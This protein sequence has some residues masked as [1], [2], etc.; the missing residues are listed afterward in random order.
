MA[1]IVFL[2]IPAAGHV[3]PTLGVLA[4]LVK[5]GHRVIAYN[6][7]EYRAKHERAGA[8]FRAYPPMQ[9]YDAVME[10]MDRGD[11]AFNAVMLM[12]A[13]ERVL[14]G[15]MDELRRDQ[16]D[17]IMYDS[18]ASWGRWAAELLG[19]AGVASITT[20]VLTPAS[21]PRIPLV[22]SLKMARNVLRQMPRYLRV[23]SRLKRRNLTELGLFTALMNTGR[24]NLVYTSRALQPNADALDEN[25]VFVG[26]SIAE[27]NDSL[28]VPLDGR[29]LIYVSLGTLHVGS[30]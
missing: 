5:R 16:P 12:K 28:D 1:T 9:E 8:E 13:G 3:N 29:P 25:Y 26:A 14:S 4:E 7:E 17:L 27:R 2:N 20:F 23:R 24:L 18:L 15:L 19:V 10:N 22:Q 30:H 21:M 11:F 6:N